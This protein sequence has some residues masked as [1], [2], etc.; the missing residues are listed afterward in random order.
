VG[1]PAAYYLARLRGGEFW[2]PLPDAAGAPVL[3]AFALS[4]A[5]MALLLPS[6]GWKAALA[7]AL[8]RR[9]G[10][11]L[12]IALSRLSL[13]IVAGVLLSRWHHTRGTVGDIATWLRLASDPFIQGSE[14]LG[15]WMH[16][17]AYRL[18]SLFGGRPDPMLALRVAS[19]GAGL[20]LLYG[21]VR[22]LPAVVPHDKVAA[23]AVFFLGATFSIFFFGYPATTPWVCAFLGVYLLAGL[24]YLA[25]KPNRAPWPETLVIALAVWTHGAALFATGAQATLILIWLLTWPAEPGVGKVRRWLTAAVLAASP[26]VLL[27]GTLW[28]AYRFGTGLDEAPWMGT[29]KGGIFHRTW[30]VFEGQDQ[31]L[32]LPGQRF[33]Q[34]VFLGHDYL[35]GL[36]NVILWI[37]P[38]LVLVPIAAWR[39][40]RTR[41][42]DVIFLVG[43]LLGLLVLTVFWNPDNGHEGDIR[44]LAIFAIP[45]GLLLTLWLSNALDDRRWKV[46]AAL[47]AS[48][49]FAF[50]IVPY[51]R[52]P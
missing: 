6:W 49:A 25:L 32:N 31:I 20:F 36:V 21:A 22:L 35:R 26:F 9:L 24:R 41:R 23:S 10:V 13:V 27:G 45:A 33:E 47:S 42:P 51:L 18:L 7:A 38:G 50:E 3:I 40:A 14:P 52:F 4:L 37:C 39:L 16:Y 30:V 8:D 11:K 5:A 17:F 48:A 28:W 43:A 46:L 19:Y 15:R 1:L 34:Y 2:L 44:Y 12:R 29:A